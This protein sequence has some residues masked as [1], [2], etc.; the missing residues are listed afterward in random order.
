M[1]A[2][3]SRLGKIGKKQVHYILKTLCDRPNID[4][5]YHTGAYELFIFMMKYVLVSFRHKG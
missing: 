4:G 5:L 1:L 2:H 3:I